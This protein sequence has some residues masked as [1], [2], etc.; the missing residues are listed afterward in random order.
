MEKLFSTGSEDARREMAA[1]APR[2]PGVVINVK[3][4]DTAKVVLD[5]VDVPSAAWGLRRPTDPGRHVVHASALGFAAAEATVT[6]VEGK[7]ETVTLELRPGSGGPPPPPSPLVASG[8][9]G[10][11]GAPPPATEAA[12]FWTG[13]RIGGAVATGVGLVGIGVGSALGAVAL[14]K[15][16]LSGSN[17]GAAIG[18]SDPNF[19]NATGKQARNDGLSAA[20][21]STGA[22]VAG[23][24]ILAGGVTLLAVGGRKSPQARVGVGPRS[25]DVSGSW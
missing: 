19:C 5:G 18:S 10:A 13:L 11:I 9:T 14:S 8:N 22:F 15:K 23:G 3:G 20:G 2:V 4:T 12:S 24:V 1:L 6:L 7:T 17:C 16:S 21:I 25:I